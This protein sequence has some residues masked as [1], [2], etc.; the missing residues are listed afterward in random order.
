MTKMLWKYE[1]PWFSSNV[2]LPWTFT[3]RTSLQ[4]KK[5]D[6]TSQ[7]RQHGDWSRTTGD[8]RRLSR[9][10]ARDGCGEIDIACKREIGTLCPLGKQPL[11]SIQSA[12]TWYRAPSPPLRTIWFHQVS[13]RGV[14]QNLCEITHLDCNVLTSLETR[15]VWLWEVEGYAEC[16][17]SLC[18]CEAIDLREVGKR[19]NILGGRN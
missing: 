11:S 2:L 9:V 15:Y 16:A 18:L 6:E 3:A 7:S 1:I 8:S 19:G 14:K 10:R 4:E 12:L 5:T 13:S 17:C